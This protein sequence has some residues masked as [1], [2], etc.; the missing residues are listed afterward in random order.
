MSECVDN[1]KKSAINLRVALFF[2]AFFMCMHLRL[3]VCGCIFYLHQ[4][5]A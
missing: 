5:G 2:F 1:I 3:W 4:Q